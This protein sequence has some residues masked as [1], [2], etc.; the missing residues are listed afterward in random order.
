MRTYRLNDIHSI[1]VEKA[2]RGIK[3]DYKVTF[4]E[5]GVQLG[6]PDYYNRDCLEWQYDITLD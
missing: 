1:T 4:Y 5:N 2:N 6:C 3:D